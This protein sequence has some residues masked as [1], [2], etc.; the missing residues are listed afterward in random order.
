MSFGDDDGRESR[1][2][3]F[4][5]V[6]IKYYN[7]LIDGKNLFDQ[8]IKNDLKTYDNIRKILTGQGNEYMTEF[9]LD[10]PYFK[11]IL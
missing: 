8:P 3:L 1:K 10:F 5:T 4:P 7:I 9:L 6:E 11:K 2:K